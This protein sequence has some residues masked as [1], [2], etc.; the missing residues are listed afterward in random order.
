MKTLNG[1][2]IIGVDHGYGNIKTANCCFLSGV[3]VFDE[4]PSLGYDILEYAGKYHLIGAE[5]KIF[6]G[7]KVIDEDYYVLTLAAIARE[8]ALEHLTEAKVYLAVGLPLSWVTT[9]RDAFSDYLLKNEHV[10]FTFR[11]VGYHIDFVGCKV[12]PQGYAAVAD[13]SPELKGHHVLCDVGN[14]TMNILHIVEGRVDV[15]RM[16]TEEYGTK[17]CSLAIREELMRRYQAK[18]DESVVA[19]VLQTGTADISPDY[20]EIITAVAR[21]YAKGIFRRL[22]ERG[23][24][25]RQM[26]LYVVGGGGCVIR[27]FGEYDPERTTIM[28]DICATAK[29]YEFMAESRILRFGTA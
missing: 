17:E 28:D 23:Y 9:Q 19:R 13:K 25:P 26:R 12:F 18:V 4:Q 7:V 27:N 5:H 21:K 24:D 2:K 1:F 14:G 15:T 16:F 20:L 10:D 11:N 22:E 29:G 3:T 8:L 6:T